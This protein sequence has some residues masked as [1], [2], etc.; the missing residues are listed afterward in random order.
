MLWPCDMLGRSS[1]DR[2][3]AVHGGRPPPADRGRRSTA[4]TIHPTG[5]LEWEAIHF[6]SSSLR[7]LRNGKTLFYERIWP[8]ARCNARP[9]TRQIRNEEVRKHGLL[10]ASGNC[11]G[12]TDHNQ[13]LSLQ[14]SEPRAKVVI[15]PRATGRGRYAA[16]FRVFSWKPEPAEPARRSGP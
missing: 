7:P 1:R 11:W 3:R 13:S 2:Q 6:P 16:A 8:M 14:G 10:S 15:G 5:P 4:G 12:R 9:K